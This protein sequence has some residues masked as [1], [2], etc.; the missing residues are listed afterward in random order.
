MKFQFVFTTIAVC[1]VPFNSLPMAFQ[2]TNWLGT[3][4]MMNFLFFSYFLN[5]FKKLKNELNEE[6]QFNIIDENLWFYRVGEFFYSKN[7]LITRLFDNY[8]KNL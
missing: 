7:V 2:E 8:S 4:N 5:Q 6:K 3:F 1:S